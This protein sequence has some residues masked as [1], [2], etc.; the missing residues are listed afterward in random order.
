MTDETQ[1]N[2]AQDPRFFDGRFLIAIRQWDW[3]LSVRLSSDVTPPQHRFRG[4]LHY[5]REF[6][7]E[8]EVA[9]PKEY[10]GR[11]VRVRI[12]PFDKSLRFGPEYYPDVG[13]FFFRHQGLDAPSL[14]LLILLP[15]DAIATTA[16]AL[17]SV[18]KYLHV[19]TGDPDAEEASVKSYSFSAAIHPN[20]EGWANGD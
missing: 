18:W 6:E 10:R 7:I 1:Q 8:G 2:A 5:V 12:S 13:R 11:A 9:A 14:R 4:G 3:P 19:W 16:C 15:E 20:L 17:A